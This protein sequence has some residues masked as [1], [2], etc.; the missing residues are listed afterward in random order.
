MGRELRAAQRK[1]LTDEVDR[2]NEDIGRELDRD[3]WIAT[4]VGAMKRAG[5]LGS[6]SDSPPVTDEAGVELLSEQD[7]HGQIA[8]Q[9]KP[10]VT[11]RK[12]RVWSRMESHHTIAAQGSTYSGG[13]IQPK[14]SGASKLS[15]CP[16]GGIARRPAQLTPMM[17][18]EVTWEKLTL[19]VDSGASDT[20]VPP[21]FCNWSTIFHTD[22]VGTE[23]EIANGQVV[24]NLGE[25]RC[26][27]KSGGIGELNIA[28]QVVEVHKPLLAVSSLTT[29]GHKVVFAKNDDHILLSTGAKMPLRN[30]NGVY[31]LD[32]W[33][34]KDPNEVGFARQGPQ[35]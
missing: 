16:L 26:T 7:V 34:K 18:K 1:V 15:L 33:V 19:T 6:D 30:C 35:R 29:N 25:R 9:P 8:Q 23:Y 27:I 32:V 17:E 5:H 11:T 21:Q 28:F 2:R 22:K 3:G 24:H 14:R 31:E 4:L 13:V 20:V 12:K 10:T